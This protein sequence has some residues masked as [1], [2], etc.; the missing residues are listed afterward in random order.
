MPLLWVCFFKKTQCLR[1]QFSGS[2]CHGHE[3]QDHLEQQENVLYQSRMQPYH[4]CR[5]ILLYKTKS[6]KKQSSIRQ[7]CGCFPECQFT[8]CDPY[9]EKWDCR[10]GEK[11]Y[12]QSLKKKIYPF[13]R[14]TRSLRCVQMIL[15]LKRDIHMEPLWQIL[16]LSLIH[17]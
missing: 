3:K 1:T 5:N 10:C 11:H 16:I 14:K 4:V 12:L 6:E 13:R 8:K 17:I 7:D 15:H 2:P 9:F